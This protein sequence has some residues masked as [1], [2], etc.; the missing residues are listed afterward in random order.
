MGPKAIRRRASASVMAIMLIALGAILMAALFGYLSTATTTVRN[1]EAMVRA[2]AAAESGLGLLRYRIAEITRTSKL[3]G[4]NDI[5]LL[6]NLATKL[7]GNLPAAVSVTTDLAGV[8]HIDVDPVS[9]PD[10]CSFRAEI[11][12]SQRPGATFSLRVVGSNRSASRQIG[13]ELEKTGSMTVSAMDFPMASKSSIN[14]HSAAT[15][16]YQYGNTS[17][18][19]RKPATELENSADGSNA[20]VLQW[21]TDTRDLTDMQVV[22]PDLP[23]QSLYDAIDS[24]VGEGAGNMTQRTIVVDGVTQTI[25]R[26]SGGGT[27]NV[28]G[29]FTGIIFVEWGTRLAFNGNAVVNGM[30]VFEPGAGTPADSSS[31]SFDRDAAFTLNVDNSAL[32][33]VLGNGWDANADYA[34]FNWGI[35]APRTVLDTDKNQR[36]AKIINDGSAWVY[37]SGT[38]GNWKQ[39]FSINGGTMLLE[40]PYASNGTMDLRIN[41]ATGSGDSSGSGGYSISADSATYWEF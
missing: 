29:T 30:I 37:E 9:L 26:Y 10:E 39:P 28:S 11:W 12:L 2:Q 38:N 1:E 36:A 14:L 3:R 7:S 15:N 8:A 22:F 6:N 23:P 24:Y 13:L 18:K 17:V 33:A 5:D 34:R 16:V 32:R 27:V 41:P 35:L 19:A 20:S 25:R 31:L 4:R 40:G 21:E